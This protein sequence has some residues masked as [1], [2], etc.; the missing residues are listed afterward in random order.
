MSF[1]TSTRLRPARLCFRCMRTFVRP[2]S[3]AASPSPILSRLREDMKNAMRA[4]D[5]ARLA[6]IRSVLNDIT[7]ASKT[8]KPVADDMLLRAL[9]LKRINQSKDAAQQFRDAK[10]E[11]LAEKED[12]SASVMKNYVGE[13][14]EA[15][16]GVVAA[17]ELQRVVKETI[18][19]WQDGKPVMGKVMDKITGPG[20]AL[21]GRMVEKGDLAK[22]VKEALGN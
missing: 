19:S 21:D 4:K 22:A 6:V 15:A 9:L 7:N 17:D 18:Q 8:A 11:D 16:G 3:T 13:I 20:G 5:S 14:E 10:R 2:S 12:G 1:S